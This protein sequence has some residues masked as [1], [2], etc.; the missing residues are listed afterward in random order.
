VPNVEVVIL[1]EDQAQ[2]NFAWRY[3]QRA[4]FNMSRVR[5]RPVKE[6][7]EQ[8]VRKNYAEEVKKH[9]ENFGKRT[10]ALV[11]LI[12]ADTG[13]VNRRASQLED[14]LNQA[15]LPRRNDG[16][17]IAH[18]IP[19]RNIETWILYLNGEAV[20][21][22]DEDTKQRVRNQDTPIQPAAIAFH[23][24][25]LSTAALPDNCLPSLLAAI[26]EARRLG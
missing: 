1:C 22:D 3:L 13:T 12:D 26:P 11:V 17:A 18:L 23:S 7:G 6:G 19:K 8:H 15:K 4:G 10:G 9:R 5:K 14:E 20:S 21:E 25:T 24:M 16:E 2:Q